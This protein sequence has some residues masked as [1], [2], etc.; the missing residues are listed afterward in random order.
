MILS[1]LKCISITPYSDTDC[2]HEG[3]TSAKGVWND[4]NTPM[5]SPTSFGVDKELL[6][7]GEG[8]KVLTLW[9]TA[10]AASHLSTGMQIHHQIITSAG[11][12]RV[13]TNLDALDISIQKTSWI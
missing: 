4:V 13:H 12:I 1:E 11:F 8:T 10:I 9:T 5:L 7:L 6:R 2:N 3:L